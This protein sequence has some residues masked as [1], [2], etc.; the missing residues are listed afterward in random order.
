ML[1]TGI[2]PFSLLTSPG[3]LM[4]GLIVEAILMFEDTLLWG[5]T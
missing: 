2:P 4:G 1:F 5:G 3:G